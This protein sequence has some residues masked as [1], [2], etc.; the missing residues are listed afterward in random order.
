[1]FTR[2]EASRIRHE[3][4]TAFGKYMSPIPSAEGLKI[5][6]INYHT[7]VKDLYFRMDARPGSAAISISIEH[8]DEEI[9]QFY[10]EELLKFKNMLHSTLGEEW[11]WQLYRRTEDGKVMSQVFKDLPGVSVLNKN[12]WPD[13]ISFFKPRIIAL[14]SFWADAKYSFDFQA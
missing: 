13:L 2:A 9:Q 3:F 8:R 12:N 6:W 1:M 10:F 5:N 7:G 4:W 11:V 14:D